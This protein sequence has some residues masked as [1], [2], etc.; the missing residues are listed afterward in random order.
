MTL[1]A[2][3]GNLTREQYLLEVLL[4]K[5]EVEQLLLAAGRTERLHMATKDLEA[6]L[7]RIQEAELGRSI[8][9][10][11]ATA[12]LSLPPGAS[13]REIAEAAPAPWDAILTEQRVSLLRV[14]ADVRDL[15]D[16]NR[17]LLTSSRRAV[18]E[19][20]M[21]LRDDV[22]TYDA[23]GGMVCGTAGA[24]LLDQNF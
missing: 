2:L 1:R 22:R 8:E 6:V 4:Y 17:D 16:V 21:S 18:Q 3:S 13:L 11:S 12:E 15:G 19:T 14:L 24:Q 20:L 9:V 7:A 23:H 10:D 5:L